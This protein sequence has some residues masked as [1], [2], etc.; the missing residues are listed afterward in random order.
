MK[1]KLIGT[2]VIEIVRALENSNAFISGG[3]GLL[4]DKTSLRSLIYYTTL[5]NIAKSL[6]KKTIIFAQGIG[7]LNKNISKGIIK[8]TLNK[9]D[10][11]TVRDE[12]SKT[13]AYCV[14][15]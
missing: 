3:G 15:S 1:M 6:K 10:L 11:I 5:I 13:T 12:E 4:Q 7:P 9:V 14:W 8:K 2:N